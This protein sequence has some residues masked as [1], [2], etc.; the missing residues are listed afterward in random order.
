M[1]LKFWVGA[2]QAQAEKKH[3]GLQNMN[4]PNLGETSQE[5]VHGTG[6][7]W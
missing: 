1:S 6:V 7:V 2:Q 5:E 3:H 4:H